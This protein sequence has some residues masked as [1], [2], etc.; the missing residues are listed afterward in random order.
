MLDLEGL[1]SMIGKVLLIAAVASL[2]A[3]GYA[4]LDARIHHKDAE[5]EG[6]P[7]RAGQACWARVEGW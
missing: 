1:R 3:R 4:E 2:A 6:F 5:E 7:A